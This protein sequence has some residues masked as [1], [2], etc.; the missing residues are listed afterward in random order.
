MTIA[1]IRTTVLKSKLFNCTMINQD[2]PMWELEMEDAD[3]PIKHSVY[4][5]VNN[6]KTHLVGGYISV[7]LAAD[8]NITEEQLFNLPIVDLNKFHL[9]NCINVLAKSQYEMIKKEKDYNVNQNLQKIQ[10]DFK[11]CKHY[12]TIK[13]QIDID[14]LGV[15]CYIIVIK[16]RE[17]NNGIWT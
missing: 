5:Y 10:E 9:I 12:F 2:F 7:D 16:Q 4:L 3:F 14:S 17:V 1:E 13:T 11:Q 6:E 15:F 8:K